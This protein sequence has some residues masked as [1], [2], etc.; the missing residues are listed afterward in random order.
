MSKEEGV[1]PYKVKVAVCAS[2]KKLRS[3]QR[4]GK[5]EIGASGT[6]FIS[7]RQVQSSDR[8]ATSERLRLNAEIDLERNKLPDLHALPR[9][10]KRGELF[11]LHVRHRRRL[12]QPWQ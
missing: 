12:D 11:I 1:P 7:V 4:V 9:R 3:A 2:G 8:G 6:K 5:L 10:D